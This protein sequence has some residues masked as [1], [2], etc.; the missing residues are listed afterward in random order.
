M[1]HLK[2]LTAEQIVIIPRPIALPEVG[3]WKLTLTNS[4][5][6]KT[7][8]FDVSPAVNG[9]VLE[10]AVVFSALPDKGQYNYTLKRGD[11][12]VSWGLAEIAQTKMQPT[13]VVYN[14]P[15]TTIQYNG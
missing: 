7:L 4:I 13:R 5:T 8:S 12:V 10:V 3:A 2:Q 11:D 1:I 6:C 15:I 14:E 9:M